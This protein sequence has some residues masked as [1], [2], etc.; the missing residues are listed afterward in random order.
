N[1]PQHRERN[2]AS[3]I[4][5]LTGKIDGTLESVE[6]EDYP[7]RCHCSQHSREVDRM[8]FAVNTDS[9]VFRVKAACDQRNTGRRRDYE[10]EYCDCRV[11][12]CKQLHAPK[13]QQEIDD[14]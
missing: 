11:G 1:R 2:A 7:G 6:A 5:R 3:G 13:I 9:K 12:V 14:D 4:A 8:R 10:L